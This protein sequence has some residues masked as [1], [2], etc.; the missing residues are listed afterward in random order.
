MFF[1]VGWE[2]AD[3]INVAEVWEQLSLYVKFRVNLELH[4]RGGILTN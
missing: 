4:K 2:I 1:R 3:C